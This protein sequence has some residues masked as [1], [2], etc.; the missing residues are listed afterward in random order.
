MAAASSVMSSS[1]APSGPA[2]RAISQA[3]I[4]RTMQ[5][6]GSEDLNPDEET[7]IFGTGL[8]AARTVGSVASYGYSFI[9]S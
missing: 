1:M 9:S 4:K 2:P 7:G 8:K 6:F 3:P 5:S